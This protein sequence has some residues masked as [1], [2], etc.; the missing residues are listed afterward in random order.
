MAACGVI[1]L[2]G[3]SGSVAGSTLAARRRPGTRLEGGPISGWDGGMD[4]TAR[5]VLYRFFSLGTGSLKAAVM[6]SDHERNPTA[7]TIRRRLSANSV[8][9]R[10]PTRPSGR[11]GRTLADSRLTAKLPIQELPTKEDAMSTSR[12]SLVV[13]ALTTLTLAVS[14]TGCSGGPIGGGEPLKAEDSPLSKYLSVLYSQT[15]FPLDGT[16]EEQEAFYNEQQKK[17]EEFVATCMTKE[18]FEYVPNTTSGGV[19]ITSED[20]N[21]WKPDD[22]EWVSKYGYGA[23]D[24]PGRDEQPQATEPPKDPNQVYVEGLPQ[25]EQQAYYET[26]Y[27]KSSDQPTDDGEAA[28]YD[29]KN[30]GCMGAAQHEIYGDNV[31]DQGDHKPLMDALNKFYETMQNDPSFT[32]ID[33]EWSACMTEAGHDG[34]A[35]QQDAQ[36]SIYTL[37]NEYYEKNQPADG[38]VDQNFGT[39]KDPEFAKIAQTE[40]PLALADL[41]CREKTDYRQRQLRAQFALEEQFITDHKEELDA[42]K[43]SAGQGKGQGR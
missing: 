13:A 26:L 27:G 19:V 1:Y 42:L 43:A 41:D 34:F 8:Q 3:V 7:A 39:P 11:R 32:E 17:V 22:R 40:L 16:K 4:V 6:R 21:P 30:A 14:L 35:K 25:A 38:Q 2:W 15:G 5:T 37:I 24:Y 20:D 28:Q 29:W 9:R 31:F 36:N 33:G 23:V 10:I 18:G 12:R